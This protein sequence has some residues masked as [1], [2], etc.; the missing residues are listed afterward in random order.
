MSARDTTGVHVLL[1]LSKWFMAVFVARVRKLRG[2]KP[3]QADF[4]RC[5]R[6]LD[7]AFVIYT[8]KC[9][10]KFTKSPL[11]LIFVDVAN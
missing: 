4:V 10:A 5:V 7:H 1:L 11:F 6:T 3:Y 9:V 2:V 8:L